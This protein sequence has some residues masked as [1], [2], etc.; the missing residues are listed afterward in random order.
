[1]SFL[2]KF[3][4]AKIN[5]SIVFIHIVIL[6]KVKIK[7]KVYNL[8]S[9]APLN[10]FLFSFLFIPHF[11]TCIKNLNYCNYTFT[12]LWNMKTIKCTDLGAKINLKQ[13]FFIAS[14]L[15]WG[16]YVLL[17]VYSRTN[18][19]T[20]LQ[21]SAKMNMN[22]WQNYCKESKLLQFN[23][24]INFLVIKSILINSFLLYIE[25]KSK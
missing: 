8:I 23:D 21:I 6:L 25:S 12:I 10:I 19:N 3:L 11:S 22:Q 14:D 16:K 20:L 4:I 2:K 15:F 24:L 17:V 5:I 7:L 13:I 9:L 18:G 1:M